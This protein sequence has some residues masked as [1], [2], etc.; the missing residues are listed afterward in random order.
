M[1]PPALFNLPPATGMRANAALPNRRADFRASVATALAYAE[2]T[3]TPR[4]HMMAGLADCTIPAACRA[5]ADALDY[6]CDATP[7]TIL[8]EPINRRDMP[9]YFR[10]DFSYAVQLTA[11]LGRPNLKLQFDIYH[12]QI[13]RELDRMGYAGFVGCEYRPAPHTLPGLGWLKSL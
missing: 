8:I 9:G 12:S 4:L 5:Y 2:A 6:L 7:L 13:L 11:S 1:T 3:G 10:Y